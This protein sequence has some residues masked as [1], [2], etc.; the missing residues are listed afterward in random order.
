MIVQEWQRYGF[1][2][3]LLMV[4]PTLPQA[5]DCPGSVTTAQLNLH[6][7]QDDCWV[8]LS[9]KVYD[10]TNYILAHPGGPDKIIPRCGTDAT[11]A[12]ELEESHQNKPYSGGTPQVIC[13]GALQTNAPTPSPTTDGTVPPTAAPTDIVDALSFSVDGKF[14]LF[15]KVDGDKITF[16]IT[17]TAAGWIS[18]GFTTKQSQHMTDLDCYIFSMDNP[19]L[20]VVEDSYSVNSVDPPVSDSSLGGTNDALDITSAVKSNGQMSVTFSRDVDTGDSNG[21]DQNLKEDVYIVWALGDGTT[22]QIHREYGVSASPMNLLTGAKKKVQTSGLI[23]SI[24]IA[25]FIGLWFIVKRSLQIYEWYTQKDERMK[26][27]K[28]FTL[29]KRPSII[30][31]G[32]I[33]EKGTLKE[34]TSRTYKPRGPPPPPGRRRTS[35]ISDRLNRQHKASEPVYDDPAYANTTTVPPMGQIKTKATSMENVTVGKCSSPMNIWTLR[36]PNTQIM[37]GDVVSALLYILL[38]IVALML[39]GQEWAAGFGS[40]SAANT[41]FIIIPATRNS[42]LTWLVGLPFDEV[43]V[44]HRWIGRWTLFCV[45][46]HFIGYAE[47]F[48]ANPGLQMH[49]FGFFAALFGLVIFIT[50]L[51]FMRRKYFEIFFWSHFSFLGFLLGSIFH[52]TKARPYIFA[53]LGF[54]LLDRVLRFVGG[55]LPTKSTLFHVKPMDIVQLQFPKGNLERMLKNYTVGQYFF[56]NIPSLSKFEWHPFSVSSGP[57]EDFVEVHIRA[58]GDHTTQILNLAKEKAKTPNPSVWIRADGPYGLPNFDYRR[59]GVNFLIGGG[60]GVTPIIGMLRAIYN[61]GRLTDEQKRTVEPHRIDNVYAI[62]VIPKSTG[63]ECFKG[64]LEKCMHNSKIKEF[65]NLNLSIYVTK[66][67]DL[68]D[69]LLSGRPDFS[70]I[71]DKI[72]EDNANKSILV[73]ACG[74]SAMINKLWDESVQRA[75][76]TT[77]IDFH[78]E[79]FEF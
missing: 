39:S 27:K 54:Y 6:N 76:P 10:F 75:S 1:C 3:L 24:F 37:L 68:S 9:E 48:A 66:E 18:V 56:I 28:M 12:Y 25:V 61:V 52:I 13:Q 55:L 60:V 38:N 72:Q 53:G 5:Q 44:F 22:T 2:F 41:M 11:D 63:Y 29:K 79:T 70:T 45:L 71:F 26:D 43:I 73:F 78:H 19:G 16:S 21:K 64:E 36:I 17:G 20:P 33:E 74:P 32:P 40:L 77:R 7:G 59:Y 8:V 30:E 14:S 35:V 15:W 67:Q 62:W 49:L 47:S 50:S 42:V 4:L 46:I 31:I 51:D 23:L 58:L 69:P 65:P 34:R 57:R